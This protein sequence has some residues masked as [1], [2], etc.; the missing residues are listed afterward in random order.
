MAKRQSYKVL[1]VVNGSSQQVIVQ[2]D[3]MTRESLL[4][5]ADRIAGLLEGQL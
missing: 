3:D 1:H 5:E 2:A 4:D